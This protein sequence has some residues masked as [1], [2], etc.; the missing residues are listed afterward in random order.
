MLLVVARGLVR[1][2][3][4]PHRVVM[5]PHHLDV[6]H[7]LQ[8]VLP[9]QL[10]LALL[11]RQLGDGVD[12][13]AGAGG[14]DFPVGVLEAVLHL[15]V[16]LGPLEAPRWPREVDLVGGGRLEV[17]KDRA[18]DPEVRVGQVALQ[19]R[20]RSSVLC[21]NFRARTRKVRMLL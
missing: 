18:P 2:L 21:V 9:L 12:D 6:F 4:V 15:G 1:D 8:P 20:W 16:D 19:G 5:P 11:I 7:A 3:G 17:T 10:V 14:T 13:R